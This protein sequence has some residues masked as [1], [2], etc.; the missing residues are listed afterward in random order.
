MIC[1]MKKLI[2]LKFLVEELLG[3][4]QL[5]GIIIFVLSK[6]SNHFLLSLCVP[7]A[8]L[9]LVFPLIHTLIPPY[10]HSPSLSFSLSFYLFY[11]FFY[12]FPFLTYSASF[13]LYHFTLSPLSFFLLFIFFIKKSI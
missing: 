13:H 7:V 12:P 11:S 8:F 6:I 9:S 3:L 2:I 4:K 5:D 1:N 10:S